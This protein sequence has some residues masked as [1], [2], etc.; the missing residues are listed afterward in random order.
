M[1]LR[2]AAVL[3]MAKRAH[4]RDHVQAELM[5]GERNGAFLL[6]PMRAVAIRAG[7]ALATA[8]LEPQPHRPVQGDHGATVLVADSHGLATRR[9]LTLR[10]DERVFLLWPGPGLPACH[11]RL[12]AARHP[13]PQQTANLAVPV[14]LSVCRMVSWES[15]ST[16]PSSTMRRASRRKLQRACPS[17]GCRAGE[18]DEVGFLGAV[19]LGLVEAFSAAIRAEGIGQ[20]ALDE[21]SSDARHGGDAHIE[22]FGDLGIA[23]GGSA[24]GL[25]GLE[26]DVGVLEFLHVGLAAGEQAFQ[27]LALLFGE[28]DAISLHGGLHQDTPSIPQVSSPSN[29]PWQCTSVRP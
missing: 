17:G 7:G 16:W 5:L 8:D 12:L 4:E 28:R 21:A 29:H 20:A 22:G 14:F 18:R 11:R 23:P 25:I 9:T 6:G 15:V 26:Q 3:A 19:E 24:R 2:H 1:D 13:N 10:A 27:V